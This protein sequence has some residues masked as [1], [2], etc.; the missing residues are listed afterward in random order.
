[1][2]LRR[3]YLFHRSN[4]LETDYRTG[5]IIIF[6]FLEVGPEAETVFAIILFARINCY[7]IVSAIQLGTVGERS[8]CL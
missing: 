3:I 5:R 8:R 4:P 2:D 6:E 7:E 1:M